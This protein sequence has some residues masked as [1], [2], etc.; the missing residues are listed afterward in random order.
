M[1]NV[2]GTIVGLCAGI[3]SSWHFPGQL[4]PNNHHEDHLE[5]RINGKEDPKKLIH[6]SDLKPGDNYSVNT[7]VWVNMDAKV[8]LHIK[9]LVPSQGNQTEPEIAEENGTPKFDVQNY[10]TYNGKLLPDMVSCWMPL[11]EIKKNK[12]LKLAQG[13]SFDP[14]VTN[15]AQG[16]KLTFTEE[17]TA[18]AANGPVPDTGS[19]R[20]WDQSLKKCVPKPTPKHEHH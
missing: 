10:L 13:F 3:I 18:V 19:G 5:L 4:P 15:W 11:G 9:D 2:F 20:V 1:T 8:Y 6:F 14:A 16:D 17:F 7:D 12:T